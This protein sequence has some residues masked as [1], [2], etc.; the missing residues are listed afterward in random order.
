[1][2]RKATIS[3][4]IPAYN[5][6]KYIRQTVESVLQQTYPD[7]ECIVVNDGSMDDTAERLADY[8]DN[9]IY[10]AQQNMGRAIA[11]NR[12]LAQASGVYVAFLDA[13]DYWAAQK[14][15]KQIALLETMPKVGVVGCGGYMVTAD[16]ER[17]RELIAAP[18][19]HLAAGSEGLARLLTLDYSLAAP[20]STLVVRRDCLDAVGGF[21]A[22]IN[23]MEEWDLLLRIIPAWDIAC[24]ME[25]LAYY[26]GYGFYT[27]AKVAP[28]RRQDKYI[29]IVE[30]ALSRPEGQALQADLAQRALAL[31]YLRGALIEYA[32]DQPA[33]GRQR[34]A[35]AAEQSPQIFAGMSSTFGTST[36]YF[37]AYLYDTLTPLAESLAFIDKVFANLPTF[38]SRNESL[39]PFTQQLVW[40]IHACDAYNRG[41]YATVRRLVRLALRD[42]PVLLKDR[43]LRSI[44][45]ESFVGR[46]TMNRVRHWKHILNAHTAHVD[47]G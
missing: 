33:A 17:V 30:R 40:K 27:P 25:P 15:E 36:A 12:G 47:K 21:D 23:T 4:I 28:R 29:E 16:G 9:I 2:E 3:V 20:L 18:Q 45:A 37:A 44:F 22:A 14:L 38:L 1:M 11:R 32:V 34:L 6:G 43:G 41:D 39:Y 46:R 42:N 19:A 7:V 31:A 5:A 24:A 13:D 10:I 26:R 8:T 35:L